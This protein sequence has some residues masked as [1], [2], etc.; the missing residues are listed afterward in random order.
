MPFLDLKK[1]QMRSGYGS[2]SLLCGM[3]PTLKQYANAF[4]GNLAWI[5]PFSAICCQYRGRLNYKGAILY[6]K[7]HLIHD[8][9]EHDS[10]I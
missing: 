1:Y 3:I 4:R 6:D 8:V 10:I 5:T 2:V 7:N 9:I